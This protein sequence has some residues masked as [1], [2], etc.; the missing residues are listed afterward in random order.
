MEK[1]KIAVTLTVIIVNN[2]PAL[3]SVSMRS[4]RSSQG[5]RIFWSTF[6]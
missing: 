2:N 6:S 5:V 3:L 4:L 1:K